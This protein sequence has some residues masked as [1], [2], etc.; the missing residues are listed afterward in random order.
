LS[1][2][3]S[4]PLLTS[5]SNLG[6]GHKSQRFEIEKG[7]DTWNDIQ[8]LMDKNVG[9]HR[10]GHCCPQ[11]GSPKRFLV[12]RIERVQNENQY[13]IFHSKKQEIYER[14]HPHVT[15]D[16][17]E[18][19]RKDESGPLTKHLQERPLLTMELDASVHEVY[20]F[21]G[22]SQITKICFFFLTFGV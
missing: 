7:S 21:H 8:S 3:F 9:V 2:D 15:P 22:K 10:F 14:L 5:F 6:D 20:L 13:D 11:G 17:P 18:A 19:P 12:T 4:P 16:I 1:L